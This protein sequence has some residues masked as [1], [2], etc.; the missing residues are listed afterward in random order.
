M[1]WIDP[2]SYTTQLLTLYEWQ[3]FFNNRIHTLKENYPN[4]IFLE[5]S[6]SFMLFSMNGRSDESLLN[7]RTA[8]FLLNIIIVFGS[9][10]CND[11]SLLSAIDLITN[12]GSASY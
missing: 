3:P 9:V 8:F 11:D 12:N 4:F 7:K 2:K 6:M 10:S 1:I 5:C